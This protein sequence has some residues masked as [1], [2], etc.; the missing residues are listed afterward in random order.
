[1]TNKKEEQHRDAQEDS[2]SFE[3][4]GSLPGLRIRYTEEA[5]TSSMRTWMDDPNTVRWFPMMEP[6]EIEDSVTRWVGFYKYKCSLTATVDGEAV[7]IATLFLQPYKKIAHQCE[8]GIVCSPQFQGKGVGSALINSLLH[9]A[10][11]RF[12]IE[13]IHCTVYPDNPAIRLYERFG[14]EEFGRQ[15]H[16]LKEKDGRYTGRVFMQRYL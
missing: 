13:L 2:P 15:E 8:F 5:D 7:G 16:W 11:E 9:L 4:R 6:Q 14:F 1:M 12:R 10:K 3:V